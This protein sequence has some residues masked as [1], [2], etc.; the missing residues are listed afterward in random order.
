MFELGREG[1]YCGGATVAKVG[2]FKSVGGSPVS[3]RA[4]S[5]ALSGSARRGPGLW[6][7]DGFLAAAL[8]Y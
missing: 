1:A 4:L 2:N 3:G 6:P 8:G 7:K 5:L